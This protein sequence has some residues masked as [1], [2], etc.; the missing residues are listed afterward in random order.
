MR[1]KREKLIA[2]ISMTSSRPIG[3]TYLNFIFDAWE[4]LGGLAVIEFVLV[5]PGR[6]RKV[7]NLSRGW[8]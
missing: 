1:K 7:K 8:N 5:R 3:I 6:N 2:I 4:R